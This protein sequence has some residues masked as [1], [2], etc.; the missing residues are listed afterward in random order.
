MPRSNVSTFGPP[1]TGAVELAARVYVNTPTAVVTLSGLN[2]AYRQVRLQWMARHD[3]GTG[4]AYAFYMRINADTGGNYHGLYSFIQGTG[5]GNVSAPV[6]G[7]LSGAPYARIGVLIGTATTTASVQTGGGIVNFHSWNST[8][9]SMGRLHFTSQAQCYENGGNCY[10]E[11][12]GQFY[13]IAPPY[14][15]ISVYPASGKV[16]AGSEFSVYGYF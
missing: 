14:T 11:H 16:Q 9:G 5:G 4:V 15:S 12:G 3:V 1:Y 2:S 10:M 13:N 8:A 7:I 6:N